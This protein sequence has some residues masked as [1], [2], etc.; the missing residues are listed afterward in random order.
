MCDITK[1]GGITRAQF[2]SARYRKRIILRGCSAS[3]LKLWLF[4]S[5][6]CPIPSCFLPLPPLRCCVLSVVSYI[7]RIFCTFCLCLDTATKVANPIVPVPDKMET[8]ALCV[9]MTSRGTLMNA[10]SDSPLWEHSF[11]TFMATTNWKTNR[12]R[13]RW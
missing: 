9:P 5:H 12:F 7:F 3:R 13:Y 1:T 2:T 8:I 6:T 11:R 10:T 4:V